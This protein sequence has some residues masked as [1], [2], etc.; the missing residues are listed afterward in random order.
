[1]KTHAKWNG[2]RIHLHQHKY[3]RNDTQIEGIQGRFK[4]AKH[5]CDCASAALLSFTSGVIPPKNLLPNGA[6]H[7]VIFAVTTQ[8]PWSHA[9]YGMS[10]LLLKSAH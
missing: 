4:R 6:F 10:S 1:M 7:A 5:T 3:V 2:A 8:V 9:G